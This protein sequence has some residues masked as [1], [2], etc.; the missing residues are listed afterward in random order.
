MP[1]LDATD[2]LRLTELANTICFFDIEATGLRG[3]YNSVL[4]VSIKPYKGKPT[5]FHVEQPGNDQRV[6]REAKRVLESYDCWV[7][8]YS[9]GFDF[10]MLNTRL[11]KWGHNPISRR[12]HIDLYYTLKHNLLTA[13]RS[14]GH[15]LSWLGTPEQKMTVG[16]DVW[17]E[18]V[19]DPKGAMP[20]MVKRC[21]S[22]CTGLQNLYMKTKHLI[23]DIRKE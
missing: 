20:T 3:D 15:L 6:I 4:V 5:T 19:R 22:D 11:L 10:P 23:R 9:K 21:E 7:G 2:F 16:A 12:H 1:K 17:N 14:Q 8:Y 13:R 18:I